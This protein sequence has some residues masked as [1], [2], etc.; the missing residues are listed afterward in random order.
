MDPSLKTLLAVIVVAYA[1]L[2]LAISWWSRGKIHSNED[3]LVAGRGLPLM[4]A[5]PTLLAAWF[6]ASVMLTATDEIRAGGLRMAALE[7]IGAGLCLI[8]AGWWLAGPLWRMQ[9]LTLGDFFRER[10]GPRAERWSAILIVPSYF[11]W[12]AAQYVA[13]ASMLHLL[14]GISMALALILVAAIGTTYT[15]LGGMWS[16]T[17]TEAA[18]IAL[19]V[20]GLVVLGATIFFQLGEGSVLAGVE[21]LWTS[22]PADKQVLVP[23]DDAEQLVGWFGVL[24][25]G[26]LGNLPSQEL[27]QRIFASRSVATAKWAC[28]LAGIGYLVIGVLPIAIGLAADQLIPGAP[29]ESTLTTLMHYFLSPALAVLFTLVVMSAVLATI[30]SAILSPASVLAQNLLWPLGKAWFERR[31]WGLLAVNRL[32]V[33]VIGGAALVTAFVGED[34]YSLL[35]DAYAAGLVSL[36]VPLLAGLYWKRGD[37]RA[38]L[39]AMAFGTSVWLVH[40]V[41]GAERMFGAAWPDEW[42]GVP[43]GLGCAGIGLAAYLVSSL[44][45]R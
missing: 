34:A 30:D 4:L 3:F 10:Y 39:S 1:L 37:E 18:Q 2:M 6:G 32:S 9:L 13:L 38:A 28:H 15:L 7:P 14:F 8:L 5:F 21:R 19:V 35:E 41:S 43:V 22:M 25:I 17:M 12:I 16:V 33:A 23:R 20:V 42:V 40:L 11:G 24:A 27:S 45:P 26:A 36:L 44:W 29:G 31:G